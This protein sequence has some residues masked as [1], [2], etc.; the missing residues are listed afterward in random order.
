MKLYYAPGA[1]SLAPHIVA[2]EAGLKLELHKVEF[3]PSGKTVDEQ[4][5][6]RINPKGAVPALMLDDGQMW[7]TSYALKALSAADEAKI[8][9]LVTKAIG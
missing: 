7:A 1:C 6:T 3:G 5:Y 8:V 4:D 9:A 2:C